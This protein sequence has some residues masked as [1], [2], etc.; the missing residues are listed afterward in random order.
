MK[1]KNNKS[2]SKKFFM[3]TI[4]TILIFT[5]MYFVTMYLSY[6][7]FSMFVWNKD[8]IIYIL[9][10][11]LR[12]YAFYIWIIGMVLII[13]FFW[14]KS[15]RYINKIETETTKLLDNDDNFIE[16]PS[17]LSQIQHSVN[18]VKKEMLKNKEMALEEQKKKEEL[19]IYLA[20]D[21]KTP[22]TSIIGYLDLILVNEELD[23]DTIKKYINIVMN[24]SLS[25]QNLIEQ[26]FDITKLDVVKIKN[27]FEKIDLT[28]LLNQIVSS[29]YPMLIEAEKKIILNNQ[30]SNI[31]IMGNSNELFRVFNNILKNS[32][33]YSLE[34]SEINVSVKKNDNMVKIY[35][36]NFCSHNFSKEELSK[37]FEKFYRG[38][39]ARNSETGGSGV[40]LTIAKQI[41]E[42]H[43]GSIC[44]KYN[45]NKITFI[46]TLP[47]LR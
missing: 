18:Y 21:L 3:N 13:I 34:K 5:I 19:I 15:F 11:F 46:I 29:F 22:L 35:I 31:F 43:Q 7:L 26:L 39:T 14:K 4:I 40:G 8:N 12:D 30:Q 16:L 44:A 45:N 41:I 1:S 36:S 9:I 42:L 17:E 2:L 47:I 32:I 38:D 20:H 23:R 6:H 10:D 24:K 27:N 33:N 37:I 28:S 25:L